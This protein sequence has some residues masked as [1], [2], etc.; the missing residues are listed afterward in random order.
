MCCRTRVAKAVRTLLVAAGLLVGIPSVYGSVISDINDSF[1]LDGNLLDEARPGID[2]LHSYYVPYHAGEANVYAYH[3]TKDNGENLGENNDRTVFAQ[4]CYDEEPL[5]GWDWKAPNNGKT[6]DKDNIVNATA[7][8]YNL[9]GDLIFYLQADRFD[10]MGTAYMGAW[11]FQGDIH[12]DNPDASGG[13]FVG[14]HQ[15]GDLLVLANFSQ[16]GDNVFITMYEW[17]GDAESGI[18]QP[19]GG[20]PVGIAISNPGGERAYENYVSKHGV[21]SDTATVKHYPPNTF[22]EGGVNLSAYFRDLNESLPCFSTALIETRASDSISAALKDF[23]LFDFDTCSISVDKE[24]VSST[25]S[26]AGDMIVNEY[27]VTVKNT[28]FGTISVVNLHDDAG[29]PTYAGDDFNSTVEDLAGGQT[30]QVTPPYTITTMTN[31]LNNTVSAAGAGKTAED[32]AVCHAV[33]DRNVTITKDCNQSLD[34]KAG[35]VVVRVDY[36]GTV[37][38][39]GNTK[40]DNVAVWDYPLGDYPGAPVN[41]VDEINTT[42]LAPG[43]CASYKGIYYPDTAGHACAFNSKNDHKDVTRATYD[44]NLTGD[45]NLTVLGTGASCSLC[46]ENCGK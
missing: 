10:N 34:E 24:C 2:W 8:V 13:K 44:D 1:E 46:D 6:T 23:V 19:Y 3:R 9:G 33:I 45:T 5:S 31:D 15:D 25:V 26:A 41:A 11:L 42:V 4:K 14:A 36:W 32:S 18:L 20:A 21:D 29:T 40:L 30:K 35:Y 16:G 37:C 22:F 43:R 17:K 28:G 12:L 7:L 27:N 38:N 39:N